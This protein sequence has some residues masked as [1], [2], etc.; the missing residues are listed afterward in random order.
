MA[1]VVQLGAPYEY[2]EYSD[3]PTTLIRGKSEMDLTKLRK[4]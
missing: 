1:Y 4:V 3:V 2:D